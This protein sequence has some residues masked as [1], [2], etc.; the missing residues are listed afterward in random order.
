MKKVLVIAG[1]LFAVLVV[2]L[3]GLWLY[4]RGPD[5]PYADLDG[6]YADA[7]SHF[8]DLGAGWRVH[9]RE[10][11]PADGIPVVL[12]HGFG[13]SF[14][15]WERWVP[16]LSQRYR[17]IALDLPGHGLTQA[18]A[19]YSLAGADLAKFVSDVALRI[20]LPPAVVAGNSLGGGVAW[21]LA[22]SHPEQVRAL[23]LVDAAGFPPDHPPSDKPLAFKI[24]QYSLGRWLLAQRAT[25]AGVIVD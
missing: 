21:Q 6:R 7:H 18:P 24:L 12:L 13:D 3:L 2:A 8:V 10:E 22:V 1:S 16:A 11:G 4:W 14:T 20:G 19:D 23:V 17:V 5:I 25:R 15:S 9:Y